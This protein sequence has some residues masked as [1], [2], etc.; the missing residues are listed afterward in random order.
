MLDKSEIEALFDYVDGNL[1][2]KVPAHGYGGSLKG[3]IA[4]TL[5]RKSNTYTCRVVN[6]KGKFYAVH[7]LVFMLFNGYVPEQIDHIDRDPLNNRIENLRAAN[8]SLQEANKGIR[9][10]NRS[11]YKGVYWNSQKQKWQARINKDKK[12]YHLGFFDDVKLAALAYND[13]AFCLFN[14][15]AYLNEVIY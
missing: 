14:D 1:V 15:F 3:K 10:N 8:D 6:C 9:K 12:A 7:S 11:G 4:G 2:W 5:R 13:A